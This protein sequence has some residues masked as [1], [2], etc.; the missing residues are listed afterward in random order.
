MRYASVLRAASLL[1]VLSAT[2]CLTG[3]TYVP[4]TYYAIEPFIDVPTAEP[5]DRV[6]AIRPLSAA[7]PYKLGIVFRDNLRVGYLDDVEWA[8]SPKDVM[9]RALLDAIL[10]TGRFQDVGDTFHVKAPDLILTGELLKFDQVRAQDGWTAECRVR[11]ELRRAFTGEA[12][13]SDTL[14]SVEALDDHGP[15]A[16]AKAMGNAI[17][18]IAQNAAIQ[19][20]KH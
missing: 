15:E 4:R 6:V 14:E 17:G 13:W 19:I 12:L 11:L 18:I 7:R 16:L 5:V 2:A 1:A 10:A 8:E 9:T 3:G 20:A